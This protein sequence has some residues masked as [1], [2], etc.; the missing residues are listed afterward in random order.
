MSDPKSTKV[1]E[2]V[3]NYFSWIGHYA[4]DRKRC[5]VW[6]IFLTIERRM[7]F[8][9]QSINITCGLARS[10]HCI[11][12]LSSNLS[13]LLPHYSQPLKV[14]ES[15]S[16]LNSHPHMSAWLD[17]FSGPNFAFK[18]LKTFLV[19]AWEDNSNLKGPDVGQCWKPST[20]IEFSENSRHFT[21]HKIR[22]EMQSLLS[23]WIVH[24]TDWN[25]IAPPAEVW[26]SPITPKGV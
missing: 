22:H 18:K 7:W 24:Q 8:L 17:N 11:T 23:C 19:S 9:L 26:P 4:A 5:W 21:S 16:L 25:K 12:V 15:S 14:W 20:L 6:S 13:I 2:N 10:E 1:S 3:S